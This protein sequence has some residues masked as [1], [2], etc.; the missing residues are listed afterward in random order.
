LGSE[1]RLIVLS[2]P[3]W[4]GSG[5]HGFLYSG[6]SYTTLDNPLA[7]ND[8]YPQGINDAGQI[9]GYYYLNNVSHGFVYSGG[10]YTAL[11]PIALVIGLARKP[12]MV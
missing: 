10:S 3:L 6:D 1:T 5:T 12:W 8:T 4:A 9:V 7:P 11:D 2:A